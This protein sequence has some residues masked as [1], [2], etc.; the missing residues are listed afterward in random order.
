MFPEA[1]KVKRVAQQTVCATTLLS[2]ER[3]GGGREGRRKRDGE[4]EGERESGSEVA[5][6]SERTT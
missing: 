1:Y 2:F 5:C 3:K 4:G 6:E